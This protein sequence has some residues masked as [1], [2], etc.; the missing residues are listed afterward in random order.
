MSGQKLRE[1]RRVEIGVLAA[2]LAAGVQAAEVDARVG[3]GVV[4]IVIERQERTQTKRTSATP[5]RRAASR[6]TGPAVPRPHEARAEVDEPA[7]TSV[8]LRPTDERTRPAL[9]PPGPSRGGWVGPSMPR[10][11]GSRRTRSH[12]V[13]APNVG[14][15]R[16]ARPRLRVCSPSD[17]TRRGDRSGRLVRV[18]RKGTATAAEAISRAA[19]RSPCATRRPPA[20][21]GPRR[22]GHRRAR[23]EVPELD[24]VL[25]SVWVRLDLDALHSLD[26]MPPIEITRS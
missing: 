17:Q 14:V 16:S 24:E 9:D 22:T 15:A 25:G 6:A 1:G 26:G 11:D 8:A 19:S 7:S 2:D 13:V 20:T 3:K 10:E 5:A 23:G 4:L 12:R 18:R 21:G